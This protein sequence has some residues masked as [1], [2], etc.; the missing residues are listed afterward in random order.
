MCGRYH[1]DREM[2]MEI[3]ELWKSMGTSFKRNGQDF[4]CGDICPNDMAPVLFFDG[5]DICC[6]CQRF[7]FPGRDGQLIFNAR[8]ESAEEKVTFR[9]SILHRR[10]VIP[11]L[12]FYEWNK[13]RE[14]N[15]FSRKNEKVM[16]LAGCFNRYQGEERFVILTTK[17]NASMKPVHDRMPLILEKDEV[18]AWILDGGR[19]EEFLHK[20][21]DL[22]ERHTD[23]EQMSLFL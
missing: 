21:P 20:T 7:G 12:W 22:L 15:V 1:I 11:A 13:S 8:S 14:K 9:E 4:F 5:K 6:R 23:Y 17:A 10:A 16:Y 19:T 3:E 18:A 2:V